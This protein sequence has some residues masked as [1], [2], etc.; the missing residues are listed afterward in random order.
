MEMNLPNKLTIFRVIL[1]PFFMVFIIFPI[2][3][4]VWSRI[5][6]AAIFIIASFTDMLD[7]MIARKYNLV[8]DL[9]KFLDPLA[10]KLLVFGGM[11]SILVHN[12]D[13]KIFTSIFV[14]VVFIFLTRELAV[15]SLR[16]MAVN[17]SGK[18]IAA[19]MLGKIKTVSQMLTMV[20]LL[21]EPVIVPASSPIG[22]TN[23]ISYVLMAIMTVMTVWSGVDYFIAFFKAE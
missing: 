5:I 16:L 9:G 2:L 10:D 17:K 12:S 14:W 15:T 21:L 4:E 7:G 18:V 8:T 13:D 23:I 3:P 20:S 22:G 11:L 6:A 1:I 19:G